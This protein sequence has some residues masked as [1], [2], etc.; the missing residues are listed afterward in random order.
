MSVEALT[1]ALNLAPVPVDSN[2]KPNDSCAFV[3]VGLADHA[4]PDGRGAFPSVKT[5]MRYT[6]K[7]ERTVDRAGAPG[8]RGPDPFWQPTMLR[9]RDR[10]RNP[11][12]PSLWIT[13]LTKSSAS[14]ASGAQARLR[15]RRG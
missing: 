5:L 10:L 3:L 7:S 11:I 6:R 15:P 2:G 9:V 12:Y 14:R 1:W 13:A 8:C 4:G